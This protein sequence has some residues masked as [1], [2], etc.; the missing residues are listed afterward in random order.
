[1]EEKEIN[2]IDIA[3]LNEWKDVKRAIRYYYPEDKNNYEGLFNDIQS[4]KRKKMQKGEVIEIRASG[5]LGNDWRGEDEFYTISTNRYSM[6]FRDW[7]ELASIP[8]SENTFQTLTTCDILAHFIWE[9]TYYGTE[10][11]AKKTGNMVFKL[12]EKSKLT[13]K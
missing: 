12:V 9:I 4:W 3:K 10:E 13:T 1:M 5:R 6:S 8:I 7:R 11:E 2:I